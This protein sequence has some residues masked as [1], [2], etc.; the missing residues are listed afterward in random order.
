MLLS[1]PFGP[2]LHFGAFYFDGFSAL[3]AH[4]MVVMGVGAASERGFGAGPDHIHFTLF[5]H[6]LKI[7]VDRGETDGMPPST[8]LIMDLLRGLELFRLPQ[9][10]RDGGALFGAALGSGL[11]HAPEV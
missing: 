7:S 8:E 10:L 3:A 6:G 11:G 2:F 9:Q 4:Q 1:H 5:G